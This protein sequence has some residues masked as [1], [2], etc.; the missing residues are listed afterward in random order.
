MQGR[1]PETIKTLIKMLFTEIEREIGIA[2][3]DIEITVKEQ[4]PY[5]WGFRG[6]TGNEAQLDYSI[7][8]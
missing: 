7:K 4:L 8:V 2:P 1:K 3:V 5:C 6:M